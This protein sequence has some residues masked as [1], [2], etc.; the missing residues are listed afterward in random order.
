ML[1]IRQKLDEALEARH[2]LL[3][4]RARVSVGFGDRRI[5]FTAATLKQLDA[6]IAELRRKLAGATARGRSRVQYVVP[7]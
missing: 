3:V 6:Y 1:T 4:G 2:Q 5:E 7:V